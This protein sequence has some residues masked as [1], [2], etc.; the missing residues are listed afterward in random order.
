MVV[1]NPFNSG[2][3][4]GDFAA[5][6][7]QTENVTDCLL[8]AFQAGPNVISWNVFDRAIGNDMVRTSQN[9]HFVPY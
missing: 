8:A 9:L 5:F 7:S 3:E 4:A 2:I 1:L 6:I